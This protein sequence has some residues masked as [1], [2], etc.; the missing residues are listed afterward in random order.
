[1][2]GVSAW[3]AVKGMVAYLKKH[4]LEIFGYY[5]I[6]LAVITVL[7]LLVGIIDADSGI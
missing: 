6:A 2:A 7:L 1:V 5:R 3:I 4:G